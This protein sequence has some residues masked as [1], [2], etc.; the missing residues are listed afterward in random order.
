MKQR[1]LKNETKMFKAG[2]SWSFRVTSQD[3]KA[4]RADKDTIFEKIIDPNGQKI[5]FRKMSAVDPALKGFMDD[6][7]R[8]H[9]YLMHKLEDE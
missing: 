9:G 2:N 4:L 5:T 1:P 3:R 8:K 6:F 7:Y